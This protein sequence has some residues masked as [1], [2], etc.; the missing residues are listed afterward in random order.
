MALG[1][2]VDVGRLADDRVYQPRFSVY[3]DM[4]L[5]SKVPLIALLGLVHFG[6]MLPVSVF[7]GSGDEGGINYSATLEHK[8]LQAELVVDDL[9]DAHPIGDP[10]RAV[11]ATKVA[12]DRHLEQSFFSCKV[13][14][15]R[16]LLQAMDAQHHLQIKRWAP[17]PGCRFI[18]RHQRHQLS[19]WH[20]LPHLID[21]HFLGMR[22]GNTY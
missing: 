11:Q 9:Q 7:G 5:H 14:Q 12:A 8:A 22:P 15:S 20:Y 10:A 4:G 19:P 18:R 2:I 21:Q 1:D 13:R 16:L 6:I 3:P 17:G